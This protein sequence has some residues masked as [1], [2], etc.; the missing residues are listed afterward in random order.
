MSSSRRWCSVSST[1]AASFPCPRN[2]SSPTPQKPT[3]GRGSPLVQ[4]RG[5]AT[6]VLKQFAGLLQFLPRD[7][8]PLPFQRRD[9][10][11]AVLDGLPECQPGLHLRQFSP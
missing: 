7:G 11:F 6:R 5:L 8:V 9:G 10:L 1:T 4:L 2:R 3:A